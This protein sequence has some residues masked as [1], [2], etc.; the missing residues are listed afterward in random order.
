M[1]KFD[2]GKTILYWANPGTERIVFFM[3]EIEYIL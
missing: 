2:V 3:P 1:K